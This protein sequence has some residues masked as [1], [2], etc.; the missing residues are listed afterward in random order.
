MWPLGMMWYYRMLQVK[1]VF[2]IRPAIVLT[3]QKKYSVLHPPLYQS[4]L[5]LYMH[6]RK[7]RWIHLKELVRSWDL[8]AGTDLSHTMLVALFITI[9]I[10]NKLQYLES[11]LV[12]DKESIGGKLNWETAFQYSNYSRISSREMRRW[13][14]ASDLGRKVWTLQALR[15]WG[16]NTAPSNVYI[17]TEKV[18]NLCETRKWNRYFKKGL[19]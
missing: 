12:S 10:S 11:T 17:I 19:T 16:A 4:A 7:K 18:E 2:L 6:V 8:N 15:T 9:M 5:S 13:Q 1:S 3:H 14:M